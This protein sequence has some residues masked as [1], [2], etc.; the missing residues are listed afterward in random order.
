MRTSA[1]RPAGWTA[2]PTPAPS[3]APRTE[4]TTAAP[5]GA[6][7]SPLEVRCPPYHH[8]FPPLNPNLAK[9]S[10]P[11]PCEQF[12]FPLR[13][14]KVTA[15]LR[16]FAWMLPFMSLNQLFSNS[17]SFV[18]QAGGL[19][20]V[21]PPILMAYTTPARPAR[22]ATMALSGT[23]GRAPI[24]WRRWRPWWCARPI[25]GSVISDE[26]SSPQIKY[27]RPRKKYIFGE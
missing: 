2:S 22:C 3:S 15:D 5:A 1:A 14:Y 4:T 11:P 26:A 20:R 9:H 23:T 18:L 24:W 6:P 25:S 16:P 12:I 21:A 27:G 7:S 17:D 10:Y 19:K 13:Q 8:S